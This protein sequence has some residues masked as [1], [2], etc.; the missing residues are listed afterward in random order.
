VVERAGLENR[1]RG[2]S[3]EGSN[4]SLSAIFIVHL[5]DK[6]RKHINEIPYTHTYTHTING[7]CSC[8]DGFKGLEMAFVDGLETLLRIVV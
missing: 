6:Y 3:I 4:P 8:F 7:I 5:Y 2:N 1:Y